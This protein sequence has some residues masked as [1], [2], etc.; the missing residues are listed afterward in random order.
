[1]T[2]IAAAANIPTP[3]TATA[4]STANVTAVAASMVCAL[5]TA[6][7]ASLPAAAAMHAKIPSIASASDGFASTH[8]VAAANAA[9]VATP[10]AGQ[11]RRARS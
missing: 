5:T 10:S 3:A 11:K 2:T 6:S 7:T 9:N 8:D 1:M 4:M